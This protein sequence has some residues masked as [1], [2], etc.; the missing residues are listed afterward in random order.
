MLWIKIGLVALTA[1]SIY[2]ICSVGLGYAPLIGTI[3]RASRVNDVLLNLSYSYIAG[4]IFYILVSY[5]PY[6]AKKKKYRKIIGLKF[7]EIKNQIESNIQAFE[8]Q[9]KEYIINN[10]S[11]DQLTVLVNSKNLLDNSF[12]GNEIGISNPI[13]SLVS[14]SRKVSLQLSK[15]VLLYRDYMSEEEVALIENVRSSA[16][17]RLL[18]IGTSLTPATKTL[19]VSPQYKTEF[20]AELFNII[21]IV[22]KL[23]A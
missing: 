14:E 9:K 20:V 19:I 13:F 21:E 11:L 4:L 5:L 2:V 8:N 15:E 17:F 7:K 16:F 23:R 1:L 22:R 18:D 3:N 12:Y 6:V 10:I